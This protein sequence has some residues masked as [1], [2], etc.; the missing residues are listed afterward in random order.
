MRT[1]RHIGV[2]FAVALVAAGAL[3]SVALAQPFFGTDG[4]DVITGTERHDYIAGR[5]GNDTLNALGRADLV[6]GG[7]GNDTV[8]AGDGNDLAFGGYDDDTVNG[9]LGN[10]RVFANRGVD[11]VTGGPGNDHLW[12]RA[13]ADVTREPNEPADTLD[14]GEGNDVFHVRDGEA[15]NVTCGGGADVV[16]ADFKDVVAADCEVVKRHQPRFKR[17][18]RRGHKK[19]RD[20]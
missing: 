3:A 5:R 18:R 4:D 12:A 1:R 7:R 8:N 11:S 10:D 13:P 15:D 2:G 16:R 19:D 17:D 20:D 6:L 14:G 9:E